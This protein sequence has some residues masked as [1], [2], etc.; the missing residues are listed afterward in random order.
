[1]Q[2]PLNQ[3]NVPTCSSNLDEQKIAVLKHLRIVYN[4]IIL[5]LAIRKTVLTEVRGSRD[6]D[7]IFCS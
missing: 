1:M 2:F 7:K 5:D 6:K 4:E 3:A